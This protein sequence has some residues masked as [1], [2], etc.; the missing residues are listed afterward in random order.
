MS[1]T[2][3]SP[4]TQKTAKRLAMQCLSNTKGFHGLQNTW[5]ELFDA[6][7]HATLFNSWEWLFSWWQAYG[8]GKTLRVLVW[9]SADGATVLGIAP[10][11]LITEEVLPGVKCRVLRFVGDG[12]SD[13]DYLD[14]L[15]RPGHFDVIVQEFGRWLHANQEWDAVV[16]DTIPHFSPSTTTL[17]TLAVTV[18]MPCRIEQRPCAAVPLPGSFESFL[19]ALRPRFRTKLRSQLRSFE[20]GGELTFIAEGTKLRERLHSLFHL[21]QIRWEKDGYPGVFKSREKRLFYPLFTRRFARKGWLR[22]YSLKNEKEYLAHQLCFGRNGHTLLLQEGFDV[23]NEK[24]SYGQT[25]RTLVFKDIIEK[26]EKSYDF[27]GGS[28][29]HKSDWG[30]ASAHM[31]TVIMGRRSWKG[32]IY[33]KLPIWREKMAPRVKKILPAPLL[34]ALRRYL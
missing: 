20:T 8:K 22:F 11:Y 33:F 19:S 28:S 16:L 10:L 15:V 7:P 5:N 25:L 21:H 34:Q 14:F 3:L 31:K 18:G 26:G 27:L 1:L 13:S 17:A 12:S 23:V 6:C 4:A 9:N 29:K 2:A 24:A 30:A 32:K